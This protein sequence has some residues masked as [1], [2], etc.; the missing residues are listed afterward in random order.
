MLEINENRGVTEVIMNWA[1]M[2]SSIISQIVRLDSNEN[3]SVVLNQ[4]CSKRV[5]HKDISDI[6]D[7]WCHE[8]RDYR[9][10][11]SNITMC[12][13]CKSGAKMGIDGWE[14]HF[15]RWC[16][17]GQMEKKTMDC[18]VS[19]TLSIDKKLRGNPTIWNIQMTN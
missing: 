9:T 18:I 15:Q 7:V 3:V 8:S 17:H 5:C 11:D 2:F 16:V 10:Q 1:Q 12:H 13:H 4:T 6:C 14:T 19:T